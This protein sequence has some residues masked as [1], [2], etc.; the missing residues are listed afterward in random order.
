MKE[1]HIYICENS[2][3]GIFTAIYD[4]WAARYGH[5]NN[6]ILVEEPENYE[7]FS[8]FIYAETDW[9]K[10]EKVG[11]AIKEKISYEAYL[12][13]YYATLSKDK[14]KAD[15]IYRFLILGF[16]IG[17]GV[18]EHLSNSYVNH[19]SKMEQNVKNEMFH[20]EGF[21]RFVNMGRKMLLA[22]F[23]P[24]NDLLFFM[25]EHFADRLPMENWI[26][27]DERRMKAA[28]HQAGKE[29]IA[30]E[31]VPLNM[32]KDMHQLEE[33]DEFLQLWKH[34]VD[35]IAV[36]ERTNDSLQLNMLPNRFREF[37]PEVPYKEN[38]KK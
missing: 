2:T 19:I 11:C 38:N 4:A 9:K 13:V 36:K 5:D 21:L 16:V 37:M 3:A 20:Y 15:F 17:K 28:V 25:A 26:I 18:M 23:R 14:R 1:K 29:W 7:L 30:V 24:E 22:R 10:A 27:Y 31:K 35:S 33:E 34:F 6:Q 32:E 12:A 8:K